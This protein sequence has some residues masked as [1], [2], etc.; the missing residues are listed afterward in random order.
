MAIDGINELKKHV[1]SL[2][3]IN[4]EKLREIYGDLK[5]SE[6]FSKADNVLTIAAKSIAEIITVHGYI[7][8][9]FADVE[10]VMTNSGVV[11]MGSAT[12]EGKERAARV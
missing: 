8:V 10:A 11:I 1:D 4:N 2:L 12:A 7:N 6:A 9:D 3:V 5:L